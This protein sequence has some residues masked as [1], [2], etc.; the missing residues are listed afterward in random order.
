MVGSTFAKIL[1]KHC[2][3]GHNFPSWY[4]NVKILLTLEKI[5]YVLDKPLPDIPLGPEATEDEPKCYLLA[6]MNEE[7]QRQ[8]EG[9]DSAFSIILHLTELYGEGT[10]NRRFNTVC[11]LVKTKMVKGAPVHQ[12]V[13]KMIG[14]IEQLENLGTPLDGELAQD[15]ILASLPDSFSQFVMNYN[16]NKM[17]HTLSELLNMLNVVGTSAVA[18]NK[19]SSSK[20]KPQGK[21]KGKEKKSPT[22]KPK[23][24]VKKKKAM[25]PKGA[26]HHCYTLQLLRTSHKVWFMFLSSI[27][28][29][30]SS[31]YLYLI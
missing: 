18:Y 22:L 20:S 4:R 27:L 29:V 21:G 26:C 6:S 30:R 24:G 16:M 7:L 25:E 2:L 13:L 28:I 17:D 9:M 3:E 8:H 12:H 10:R 19:P 11:E 15:F 23:G 5:I 1:D 14:F 31:K